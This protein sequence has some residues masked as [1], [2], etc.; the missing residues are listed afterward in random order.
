MRRT[1]DSMRDERVMLT[2][3][4][5]R[6]LLRPCTTAISLSAYPSYEPSISTTL[7]SHT[8]SPVSRSRRT[9]SQT[10]GWNQ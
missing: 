6:R 10:R 8:C 5:V 9:A 4:P 7:S 3:S 2:A 1:R